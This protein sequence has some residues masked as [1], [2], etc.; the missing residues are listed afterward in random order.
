MY[1]GADERVSIGLLATMY[2]GHDIMFNDTSK[3]DSPTRHA[4]I[5]EI[6]G[7]DKAKGELY[8]AGAYDFIDAP[9]QHRSAAATLPH[10]DDD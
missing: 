8:V 6:N 5:A 9:V 1:R 7:G 10:R 2:R 3:S 4:V